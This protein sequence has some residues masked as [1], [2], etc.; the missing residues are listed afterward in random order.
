MATSAALGDIES[1]EGKG[2]GRPGMDASFDRDKRAGGGRDATGIVLE[3]Q[4]NNKWFKRGI[5][6]PPGGKME[7]EK[8]AVRANSKHR[9]ENCTSV[10]RTGEH[11]PVV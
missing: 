2:N 7:A 4:K 1:V 10:R 3:G 5:K 6:G 9:R 11:R 8:G